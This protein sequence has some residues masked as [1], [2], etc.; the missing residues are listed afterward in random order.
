[1]KITVLTKKYNKSFLRYLVFENTR[2]KLKSN[3]VLV[4]VLVL[5]FKGLL[6]LPSCKYPV[7][8]EGRGGEGRGV[9][10]G[11]GVDDTLV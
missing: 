11:K 8:G 9:L 2:K 7:V 4:V 1:M 3:L 6:S 10:V 5:Q